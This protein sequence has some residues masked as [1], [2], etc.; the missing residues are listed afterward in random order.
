MKIGKVE[1]IFKKKPLKV[2]NP[3][4]MPREANKPHAWEKNRDTPTWDLMP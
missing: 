3:G 4:G 1:K 2:R